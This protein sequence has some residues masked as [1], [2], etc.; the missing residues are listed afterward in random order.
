M[1]HNC[2]ALKVQSTLNI[3]NSGSEVIKTL[4]MLNSAANQILD[5]HKYENIK[6]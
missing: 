2:P 6:N 5:A 4:F 3:S 1:R